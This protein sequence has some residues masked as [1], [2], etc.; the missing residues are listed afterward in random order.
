MTLGKGIGGGFPL[1]ALLAKDRFC[2]FEQGDQGG[3]YCAQPLAMVAGLAVVGEVIAKNVPRKARSRGRYL[4]RRLKEI[5]PEFGL[6]D[7]RGKGLLVAVDL[8]QEKGPEVVKACFE[9][10]LLI[11]ATGPTTLRFM[12]ALNLSNA[13]VDEMIAILTGA[14]RKVL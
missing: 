10:G 14:L 6:R 9:G 5:A 2:V 1:S 4:M 13:Q 12:P 8:P 3:T 11:N 7:I